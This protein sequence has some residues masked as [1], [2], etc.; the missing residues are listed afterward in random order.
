LLAASCGKQASTPTAIP[1]EGAPKKIA[2]AFENAQPE[3]KSVAKDIQTSIENKDAPKAYLELQNFM[4][5]PDMTP[6]QRVAASQSLVAVAQRLQ[7][8]AANGD[9]RAAALLAMHRARK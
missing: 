7:S 2:V 8:D 3:L 4:S 5:R 1:L 9:Q 6:A